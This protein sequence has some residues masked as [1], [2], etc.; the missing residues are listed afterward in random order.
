MADAPRITSARSLGDSCR[1][2]SAMT[3]TYSVPSG[4]GMGGTT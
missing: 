4:K 1:R 3:G 2:D